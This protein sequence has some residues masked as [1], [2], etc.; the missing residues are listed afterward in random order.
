MKSIKTGWPRSVAALLLF[1]LAGKLAA[2]NSVH[3]LEKRSTE[4]EA[5][6]EPTAQVKK[7]HR[8][9]FVLGQAIFEKLWVSS[10]ASTKSSDGLGPLY[11]AR[12]CHQCHIANG[13]GVVHNEDG[14]IHSSLVARLT[15]GNSQHDP[16]YGRQL[17]TF[18]TAG[19]HAEGRL[20]LRYET[21]PVTLGDGSIVELQKP[22]WSLT[23]LQYGRLSAN[24]RVSARLAPPLMAS[25]LID[26]MS[27]S[28]IMANADPEDLDNDGIS[29]RVR[30]VTDRQTG[31]RVPGRFGWKAGQPNTI[32]QNSAAFATD[33]GLST[34]LFPEPW[35]DCSPSQHTCRSALHGNDGLNDTMEV[36]AELMDVLSVYVNGLAI[37][38]RRLLKD[39]DVRR[40][41]QLFRQSGCVLCHRESYTIRNS[42]QGAVESAAI[43]S[44][45]LLHDMGE[46][47]ADAQ[48]G[49]SGL[50]REWRTQPLAGIGLTK[51]VEPQAGFLH[52]GRAKTLLE[53]VLWHGGEAE[54][55]RRSVMA[56]T[57]AE[58]G[59]LIKFLE[60]L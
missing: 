26:Q 4:R 17:Q 22:I 25:G 6:R 28:Q 31:K 56:M 5:F 39:P 1:L 2:D 59:Q 42:A 34:P 54:A 44:D 60:S 50:E 48:A 36:S 24:T 20:E 49:N 30:L 18:S 8:M 29:G 52:D 57:L 35:G 19:Q 55:A 41:E 47:L 11:N 7:N 33:I 13:R 9:D 15:T 14:S 12:S 51:R 38:R 45:L 53:A 43:W 23:N 40:G 16:V 27:A 32:Q 21:L 3:S 58:R 46:G 37:P 10:P